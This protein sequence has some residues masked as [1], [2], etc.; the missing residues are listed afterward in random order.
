[1]LRADL[2]EDYN[3]HE[4]QVEHEEVFRKRSKRD[5]NPQPR[6]FDFLCIENKNKHL[7]PCSDGKEMD[8]PC[9]LINK[10]KIVA[11][12]KIKPSEMSVPLCAEV[13]YITLWFI[14]QS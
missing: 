9:L 5:A 12:N 7:V 6:I 8:F 3:K 14:K 4:F 10:G 2:E 11:C 1:M 13:G